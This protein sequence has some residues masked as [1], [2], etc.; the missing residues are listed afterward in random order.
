MWLF[1]LVE[2][3]IIK[4]LTYLGSILSTKKFSEFWQNSQIS[5]N[6]LRFFYCAPIKI[7]WGKFPKISSASCTKTFC[8]KI[9]QFFRKHLGVQNSKIFVKKFLR[10]QNFVG[11]INPC[12]KYLFTCVT[13][14]LKQRWKPFGSFLPSLFFIIN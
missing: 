9:F 8:L 12:C 7:F 3:D 5:E 10:T 13:Q 2:Q 6:F 4:Q 14:V 1:I 11:R